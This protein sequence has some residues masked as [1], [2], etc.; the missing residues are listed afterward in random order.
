MII[1][2]RTAHG[3]VITPPDGEPITLTDA[4]TDAALPA[5]IV[6]LVWGAKARATARQEGYSQG[7]ADGTINGRAQA[8]RAQ[9]I[10]EAKLA[11]DA[12]YLIATESLSA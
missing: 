7:Y 4:A 5:I 10:A 8:R 12:G 3:L 2:D 9:E 1:I 11:Q 6:T